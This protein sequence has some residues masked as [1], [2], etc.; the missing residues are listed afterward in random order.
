MISDM[1]TEMDTNRFIA[2]SL[3]DPGLLRILAAAIGAADSLV[4]DDAYLFRCGPTG[5]NVNDLVFLIAL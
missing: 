5:T 3:R 2:H 1:I 4:R